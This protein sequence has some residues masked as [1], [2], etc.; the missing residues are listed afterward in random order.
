MTRPDDSLLTHDQMKNVR[1]HADRRIVVSKS[2]EQIIDP[3]PLTKTV[4]SSHPLGNAVPRGKQRLMSAR[5]IIVVDRNGDE[6]TCLV[7]AFNNTHQI[8]VLLRET[9][10]RKKTVLITPQRVIFVPAV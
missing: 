4:D 5:E 6:R 9:G 1:R 7:E 10:L 2:F 8:L 3:L